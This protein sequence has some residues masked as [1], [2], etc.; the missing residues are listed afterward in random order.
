MRLPKLAI[1]DA[2]KS[3][4]Q[5][6]ECKQNSTRGNTLKPNHELFY[7]NLMYIELN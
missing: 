3:S 6:E 1:E 4:Y 7:V 2:E 5:S